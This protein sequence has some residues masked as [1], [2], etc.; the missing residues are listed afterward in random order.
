MYRLQSMQASGLP[1]FFGRKHVTVAFGQIARDRAQNAGRMFETDGRRQP[2]NRRSERG[3]G[4]VSLTA[5]FNI[6]WR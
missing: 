2:C 5:L 3:T 6:F 4:L 1:R